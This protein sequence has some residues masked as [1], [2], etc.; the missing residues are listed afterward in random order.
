MVYS[1]TMMRRTGSIF[2]TC[3]LLAGCRREPAAVAPTTRPAVMV[4]VR[5]PATLPATQPTV[6]AVQA[7]FLINGQPFDFPAANLVTQDRD[8][9]TRVTLFSDDPPEAVRDGYTGN[10]FYFAFD[11]DSVA[12]DDL[13][14]QGYAFR[15][16]VS[17]D[18][19]TSNGLFIAGGRQ[20]LRPLEASVGFA[21]EEGAVVAYVSGSFRLT[22]QQTPD[23]PTPP[24]KVQGRI[25]PTRVQPKR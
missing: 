11:L 22:D 4:Q 13:S 8:G 9:H 20:T 17:Q 18:E 19:E 16:S 12:T 3:V 5:A 14:G 2:V 23:G 7:T 10:S 24:V 25:E 1:M 21:T 15:N 6:A